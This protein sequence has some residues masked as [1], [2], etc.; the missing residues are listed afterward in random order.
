MRVYDIVKNYKNIRINKHVD[1]CVKLT[2]I[3]Y[4]RAHDCYIDLCRDTEKN[5][6]INISPIYSNPF[7]KIYT[8][9]TFYWPKDVP[10]FMDI[11][12]DLELRMR[13]G[14]RIV[15]VI[16]NII[17]DDCLISKKYNLK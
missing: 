11:K 12:K 15:T 5:L 14:S 10:Y 1:K 8:G 2:L 7:N 16:M 3:N 13:Q 9:Y 4:F 6:F 17:M